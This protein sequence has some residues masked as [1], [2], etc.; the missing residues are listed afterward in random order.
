MVKA[1]ASAFAHGLLATLLISIGCGSKPVRHP[2][3]EWLSEIRIEGNRSIS[4]ADL[5]RGLALQRVQTQGG[6]PDPYL[7]TIDGQRIRGEY[8]RRGFLEVDVRSRVERQR[9]AT[10]VIYTVH[11]GP[12]AKTQVMIT[13]LPAGE[14]EL[15]Q[16]VRD[17]LTLE[18]G[19]Y[20]SYEP[21]EAAKEEMLGVV[22]NAG[23]AFAQLDAHVI[24]DRANHLAVI[25]LKYEPGPKCTFGSVEISG[26]GGDLAD[27]ARARV[28]FEPGDTYSSTAL[29]ETQRRLYDMKRFSTVRV[30]PDKEG[31][32]VIDV[33][34]SLA[35]S[36]SNELTLGGGVGTDQIVWEARAR[37]GFTKTAWPFPL[38]DFSLDLRPAYA[39]LRDGTG[40]EPRLRALSRLRR[41]DLFRPYM[42]GDVEAGYNYITI[43]A[44]TYYGPLGR[45]GLESPIYTD[46]LRARVGWEIEYDSFR[47]ISPLVDPAL[48]LALGL[49]APQRVGAYTQQVSLDLRDDPIEPTFGGY[50]EIRLEE[51]TSWAGSELDFFRITPE[52]RGF[53]PVPRTSIVLAARARVGRIYGDVPVNLRYYSGGATS[54]RGFGE[55]RLA[56]TLVGIVDGEEEQV[57]IGGAELLETSVEVRV[58]LTT[59]RGMK[60]GAV[61]FL[62]GGDVT[63]K[64]QM[65]LTK[66]NWAVGVGL[67]VFTI[68]GPVRADVGYRLNRTGP[69][70]PEPGSH[71]AFHLSIGEAY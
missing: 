54:H 3:E 33:N 13:G 55:R 42:F 8:L 4:T 64:N 71:Y 25:H 14:P 6:I 9:D 2:G 17:T 5:R 36:K 40:S 34:V 68:V 31:G 10:T 27:A 20:F 51:G 37:A 19:D 67:R 44:Y 61:T 49:D 60:L 38:T 59:V 28:A 46:K 1:H 30:V 53:L 66:L 45:V 62:D 43:E 16:R 23:Y 57:P 32:N 70:N 58:P 12:R 24:A 63:A 22:E 11:E 39:T 48:E 7:V 50:A 65:D 47:H 56:P 15:Y 26:V 18:D 29:A 69:G 41:I 21:Y 52:A 35:R